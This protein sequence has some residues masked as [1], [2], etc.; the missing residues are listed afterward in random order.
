P[1]DSNDPT[2]NAP[3]PPW[4]TKTWVW[5]AIGAGA[6]VSFGAISLIRNKKKGIK[7]G[8]LIKKIFTKIKNFKIK[9]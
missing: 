2:V 4:Y 3:D 6:T 8:T 7:T 1:N 9:K 5:S